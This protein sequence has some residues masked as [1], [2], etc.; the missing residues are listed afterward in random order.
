MENIKQASNFELN[1]LHLGKN[2]FQLVKGDK[3]TSNGHNFIYQP[4]TAANKGKGPRNRYSGRADSISALK[5]M[6][7]V[8]RA[9]NIKLISDRPLSQHEPEDSEY[10]VQNRFKTWEVQYAYTIPVDSIEPLVIMVIEMSYSTTDWKFTVAEYEIERET[11]ELF[12]LKKNHPVHYRSK[13][14][15]REL[16]YVVTESGGKVFHVIGTMSNYDENEIALFNQAEQNQRNKITHAK[17]MVTTEEENLSKLLKLKSTQ[18]FDPFAS[19]NNEHYCHEC[20]KWWNW[21][22]YEKCPTCNP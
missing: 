10:N 1:V 4:S 22:K 9:E 2:R 11:K 19:R 17:V 13:I 15:K 3:F 20:S 8:L 18:G 14:E 6:K 16:N 5:Y 7:D 12:F 21:S